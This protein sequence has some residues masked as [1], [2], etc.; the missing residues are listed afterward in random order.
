MHY[1]MWALTVQ[2]G[3]QALNLTAYWMEVW[4]QQNVLVQNVTVEGYS[5]TPMIKI[6]VGNMQVG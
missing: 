3:Q 4:Q 5:T 2:N 6:F 1:H